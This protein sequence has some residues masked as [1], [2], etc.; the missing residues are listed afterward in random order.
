MADVI[1]A[2]LDPITVEIIQSALQ[3]VSD[4]MFVA[5]RKTA[6][7][8]IIY[9]VLD[10]GTGLT[11]AEGELASSGSG[12][13]AFVG[14]L[15]KAVKVVRARHSAPGAIE[16]GDIFIT[17]D[18]HYGAVTHLNDAVIV[19]PVF[20]DGEIVSWTANI[21]HWNDVGGAVPGS[22]STH[23]TE[24]F[25]EGLRLPAVKLFSRGE[26]IGPVLEIMRANSR[27]PDFL[28]GDMWAAI[29]A[30]RLGER[31]IGELVQKYGRESYLEAIRR[32]LDYGEQ[33]T[34]KALRRLP[35]GRFELAEEQDD[36][37]IFNVAVE[38]TDEKFTVD[39]RDNPDQ[40]NGPSN[41]CLDGATVVA[42]MI[43]K[44]LTETGTVC[45]GG[46]FRPLRLLTRPGSLFDAKPPAA[47]GFYFETEIRLYDLIWRCLAPHMPDRLP[48]GHFAS[49]CG[50]VIGGTH[51]DTGRHFTIVE[52][53][54]GGWGAFDGQDGATAT[55]SAFHGETFNCP[56]E[57]SEA[58]NGLFVESVRL[59]D[60]GG[61]A[62]RY[63]GG[64]GIKIDYRIRSDNC[65]LTCGYTRSRI[66]P[67]GLSG[68][69]PGT[70][71]YI[72]IRRASGTV[73]RHAFAT[74][75]PLNQGD[76]VGVVT[77]NGGGFGPPLERLRQSVRDDLRDGTVTPEEAQESYG[78][79]QE[80]LTGS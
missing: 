17:N 6:M 44:G 71:N 26:P 32:H 70:V 42:Q 56:A 35:K 28:H 20:A 75:V 52:P 55:F 53:E 40:E 49:I 7:S 21:A 64:R 39:L 69:Q 51:P 66:A 30:V 8:A 22:M 73:E 68:G 65:F 34:L 25:Q 1:A 74:G 57:I 37:R 46:T 4:E 78:Y 3:A 5:M 11:D 58:R 80:P 50:T 67:W 13:P 9:E 33:V 38:I 23:A 63:R 76:V 43:L 14:V 16:P 47:L 79:V 29:A 18:P 31:R 54:L 61:G 48:A 59:N 24:I 60:E 72:Q 45:N 10:M 15:D 2:A 27:L 36:G 62:G 12:I 19:M 77:G 41:I